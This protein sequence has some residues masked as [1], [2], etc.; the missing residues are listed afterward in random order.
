MPPPRKLAWNGTVLF[1]T[2]S[3]EE[4]LPLACNPL[5]ESI[6]WSA[7]A[8][9][10]Y[11]YPVRV[12]HF[13]VEPSHVHMVVVVD[14][15]DDIKDFMGRFKTETAH[16]INRLLGRRKRTV[17]CESYDSPVLLTAHDV[18][19]KILYLYTNPAKDG[20]EESIELYP[21]VSSWELYKAG[22][23][24]RSCP[25][26]RRFQLNALDSTFVLKQQWTKLAEAQIKESKF[27]HSFTLHPEAWLEC[28]RDEGLEELSN[29]IPQRI[30]ER[31]QDYTEQ[32]ELDKK[33][34]IGERRLIEQPLDKP[35]QSERKGRKTFC[36]SYDRDLR[37]R[38]IKAV[39]TL[40]DRASEIYQLWRKGEFTEPYP[41]GLYPPS[42]PKM[43]EMFRTPILC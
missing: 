7:L 43:V 36:I 35:H 20:L 12:C 41:V 27:S 28:F 6:I 29:S 2:T 32:R 15:P 42:M 24:T 25:Y 19:E 21:G 10:Q 18:V 11:L 40:I 34:V 9:A 33:T 5:I 30:L 17:W 31:E 1:I 38:F 22:K 14:N 26:I 23:T 3:V 37:R 13:L 39:K 8:R 16:A 4:G